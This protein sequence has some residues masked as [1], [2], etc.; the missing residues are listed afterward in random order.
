MFRRTDKVAPESPSTLEVDTEVAPA[1]Q[2]KG[3]P[4][5]TRKEAEA[6]ARERARVGMD[7]KAAQKLLREKRAA[8]NREMREG[9]KNG[10][11]KYLPARDQGPVRRYIR[12]WIDSRVS[13]T[14]FMLPMLL[15]IMA[16]TYSGQ[17]ELVRI[18][19]TLWTVLIFLVV[20]DIFWINYRLK[21]ELRAKF[22]GE[23]LKGT[24]FYV[25]LRSLQLR[26]MR[27]PKPKVKYGQRPS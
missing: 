10:V 9:M 14:E 26:F 12:D 1:T 7:K 2:G 4:T 27:M 3:R 17:D 23:S 6:A 19:N 11:E 21:K 8:A 20:L 5:P 22:P 15:V 18:G 13:F 25:L 24:T 16:L